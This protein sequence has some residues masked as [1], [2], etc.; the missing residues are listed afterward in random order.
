MTQAIF[1]VGVAVA[2]ILFIIYDKSV[3]KTKGR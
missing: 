1:M 2:V 3:N